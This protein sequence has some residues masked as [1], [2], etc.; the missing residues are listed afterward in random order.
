MRDL[1]DVLAHERA[2]DGTGTAAA[3][4]VIL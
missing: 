1:G 3:L 2:C 4:T